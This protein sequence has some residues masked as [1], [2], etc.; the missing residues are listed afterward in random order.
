[1]SLGIFGLLGHSDKERRLDAWIEQII[2]EI[3][4]VEGVKGVFLLN[5][6]GE[7]C[8]PFDQADHA[9][10]PLIA[11][12][13]LDVVQ[14]LA[15]FELTGNPIQEVKLNYSDGVLLIYDCLGLMI[16]TPKGLEEACLVIPCS[17]AINRPH[18][19]MIMKVALTRV[20]KNQKNGRNRTPV[21]QS[22]AATLT[23]VKVEPTLHKLLDTVRSA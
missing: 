19:R 13:A 20:Q 3:K 15:V 14:A 23:R 5:P 10:T 9:L 17:K 21:S 16:K 1:M 7:V 12:A 8:Y 11:E 22:K 18:L 6:Q 2:T 4:A